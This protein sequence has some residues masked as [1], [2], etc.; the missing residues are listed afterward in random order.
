M[1]SCLIRG[2]MLIDGT[3]AAGYRADIRVE[4]GVITDIATT[5]SNLMTKSRCKTQPTALWPRALLNVIP[6]LTAP[7][8]GN[9]SSNP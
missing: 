6:T 8:G 2:G 9:R 3:G 1:N 7:C 5:G 4:G